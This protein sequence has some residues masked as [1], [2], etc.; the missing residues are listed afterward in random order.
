MTRCLLALVLVLATACDTWL[1]EPGETTDVEL[2]DSLSVAQVVAVH[3][4]VLETN[5]AIGADVFRVVGERFGRR[6]HITVTNDKPAMK[7]GA[8]TSLHLASATIKLGNDAKVYF[9]EHELIHTI[10]GPDHGGE[11]GDIFYPLVNAH[12][13][14]SDATLVRIHQALGMAN[15]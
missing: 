12:A 4:A 2:S 1:V 14:W 8:E 11:L 10:L 5:A 3:N 15:E 13:Y 9:I 7:N 6:G